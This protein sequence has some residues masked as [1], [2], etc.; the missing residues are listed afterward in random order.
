[1][2]DSVCPS[3]RGTILAEA[4]FCSQCGSPRTRTAVAPASQFDFELTAS[5]LG[6]FGR[7]IFLILG[8]LL[9][10]P[11]PWIICWFYEW[12]VES[13]R[14]RVGSRLAFHGTPQ[15]VWVLTT[16]YGLLIYGGMILAL[17]T[18]FTE[19]PQ[20]WIDPLFQV[21]NNLASFVLGWYF[22]RWMIGHISLDGHRLSLTAGLAKYF[23]WTLLL[24]VSLFTIIGWAWVSCALY[25]W[26]TGTV[27]GAPGKFAFTAKGHQLLGRSVLYLL[28]ML[29][30]VTIPWV[31]RWFFAWIIEQFCYEEPAVV[32]TSSDT[33]T[34]Q[35]AVEPN[36]DR[37]AV[38]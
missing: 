34:P 24:A 20:P 7:S 38:A 9:V 36:P 37:P 15:N 12:L 16:L 17:W 22:L 3:C 14:G 4:A 25:R 1:M 30:I 29:P 6:L 19:D 31:G 10:I 21:T 27:Q 2:P 5:A 26:L 33:G 32:P 28:G 18:Q 35:A 13:V 8:F 23:G 11:A